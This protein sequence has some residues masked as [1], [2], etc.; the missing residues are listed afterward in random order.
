VTV[1]TGALAAGGC[2]AAVVA[3]AVDGAGDAVEPQALAS[4]RLAIAN[5]MNLFRIDDLLQIS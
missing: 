5:P 1:A 2:E 4:T 3:A